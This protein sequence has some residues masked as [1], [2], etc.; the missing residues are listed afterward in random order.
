MTSFMSSNSS[1]KYAGSRS[2]Q[3]PPVHPQLEAEVIMIGLL[4]LLELYGA[5]LVWIA[6]RAS[7]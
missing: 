1:F 7:G 6:P 3:S 4:D 5:V 2:F